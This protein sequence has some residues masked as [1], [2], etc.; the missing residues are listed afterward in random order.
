MFKRFFILTL[1]LLC[2]S[3]GSAWAQKFAVRG[4]ITDTTKTTMP[5][6]SV[7][8]LS[9]PDSVLVSFGTSKADGSFEV[10]KV[11]SGTYFFQVTFV[12]FQRHHQEITVNGTDLD[13]GKVVLKPSIAS[14]KDITVAADRIPMEVTKDT[15]TFAADAFKT[16][17][18]ANAEELLKKLPGVEVQSDGSIKAMGKTVDKILVDGKEFFGNDPK[19]ATQN[20]PADAIDRV[21]VFDK[22]SETT[23]FTGVDDGERERTINLK[24][25]PGKK[26]GYFGNAQGGYGS[27]VADHTS[28]RYD[29][30]FGINRFTTN[31]QLSAIGNLNNLN[32][33][34]F[35]F[36]DYMSFMGGMQNVFGGG[37]GGGGRTTITSDGSGGNDIPIGT[38]TGNGFMDTSAGGLNFNRDIAKNSWI[39]ISYFYNRLKSVQDRTTNRQNFLSDGTSYFTDYALDQVSRNQTHRGNINFRYTFKPGQDITVRS[40][41]SYSDNSY[42]NTSLNQTLNAVKVLQNKSDNHNIADGDRLQGDARLT[43][44]MRLPGKLGRSF[45]LNAGYSGSDSDTES[46]LEAVNTFYTNGNSTVTNTNQ[47]QSNL[48]TNK[49]LNGG[50][51]YTEPLGKGYTSQF[52]VN[53]RQNATDQDKEVYDVVGNQQT[54]NTQLTNQYQRDYT[55]SQGGVTL[56]RNKTGFNFQAGAVAQR[57]DLVG[58][59]LTNGSEISKSYFHILPR[60]RVNYEPKTGKNI[61]VNYDTSLREPTVQELQPVVDN[62]NPLQLYVGNP[63][64]RPEYNHSMNLNYFSFDQFTMT[65]FFAFAMVRLT[66]QKIVQARTIDSDYKQTTQPVNEGNGWFGMVN[67]NYGT[68]INPLGIRVN[69]GTN[70]NYNKGFSLVN[71]VKN[72]NDVIQ[73]GWTLRVDNKIKDIIDVNVSG[74]WTYNY[75]KSTG[76]T[77]QTNQY[78]DQRYTADLSVYFLKSWSFSTQFDYAIYSSQSF[79]SQQ[80][81]PIWKTTLSRLFFNEKAQLQLV[82]NDLLNK[83][84]GITRTSTINYIQDERIQS[85]GRYVLLRFVYKMSGFG[86]SNNRGRGGIRVEV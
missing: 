15:V 82:A 21:Q 18:N 24:L 10:R 2:M 58:K 55:Y 61:E 64:L 59:I 63:S 9:K 81:V 86:A 60:V 34:G 4:V 57:S 78:V 67:A 30:K 71:N 40:S 83:N 17:P 6:A 80:A 44:R 26:V 32:E 75:T 36:S 1:M 68:P 13:L 42:D 74:R 73:N 48:Q 39:R 19:I 56:M 7:V 84:L 29:G 76:T 50:V 52:T 79:G 25:K 11:P 53:R 77:T 65:N 69:V 31:T 28:G 54:I 45:V 49:T 22:K 38:R 27:E 41:L 33:Q 23:E 72:N 66:T 3:A 85:L 5:G 51:T 14:L 8:V 20:L 16:R 37:D 43:Y 46:T 47:L 35:S 62:T 70:V 12:G